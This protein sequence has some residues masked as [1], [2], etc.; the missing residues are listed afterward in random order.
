MIKLFLLYP[1]FTDDRLEPKGQNYYCPHCAMI[2]GVLAYYPEIAQKLEI[3]HVD[4]PRPRKQIIELLGEENQGCPC[5]VIPEGHEKE[6]DTSYFQTYKDKIFINN[7]ML[8]ARY[9]ADKF[10]VGLPHP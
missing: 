6:V 2:E 10:K 3:I 4:F 7:K 8:I 1:D 5:L 9:F